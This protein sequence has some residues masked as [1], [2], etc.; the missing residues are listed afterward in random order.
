MNKFKSVNVRPTVI[1]CPRCGKLY[2]YLG[3][4]ELAIS[5]EE[6]VAAALLGA[7]PIYYC[8]DCFAAYLEEREREECPA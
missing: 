2:T 3:N 6:G 5:K 7:L 4:A 1:R 8:G